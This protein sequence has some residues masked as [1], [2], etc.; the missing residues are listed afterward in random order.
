[1]ETEIIYLLIMGFLAGIISSYFGVGGGTVMIPFLSFIYPELDHH[2]YIASSLGIIFFNSMT[3]TYAFQKNSKIDWKLILVISFFSIIF[4]AI[5]SKIALI[6][7]SKLLQIIFVLF[8]VF[9]ILPSAFRKK[10]ETELIELAS[11]RKKFF[12]VI[13]GI[14]TGLI[15]GL[16][17]L[18]G[19]SINVPMMYR[20][21]HVDFKLLSAYS[22]AIMIFTSLS[23]V[24]I[25]SFSS[26][27]SNSHYIHVGYLLPYTVLFGFIGSF[28]GAKFGL[29][30]H[31]KSN[32]E[33]LRKAFLVLLL[34]IL[35]RLLY[36]M[37][38]GGTN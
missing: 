13:I 27:Q 1:M 17:G 15:S 12:S 4:S 26:T 8:I 33:F 14:L 9:F 6:L 10:K 37:F 38:F 22:N 34:L 25:F 28:F 32:S 30:F 35:C 5:G 19:G 3:N 21:L 36:L 24:L 2:Y 31:K 11:I 7:S 29:N 18:G 16:T 23:A 20:Y